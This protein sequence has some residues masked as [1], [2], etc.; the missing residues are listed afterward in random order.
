MITYTEIK[1][2]LSMKWTSAIK[3]A[4]TNQQFVRKYLI[5]RIEKSVCGVLK[6]K[7]VTENLHCGLQA[8][9][10]VSMQLRCAWVFWEIAAV[11]KTK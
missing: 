1:S 7:I 5:Y 3:H 4:L 11:F 8:N 2:N 10:D 6:S 9:D